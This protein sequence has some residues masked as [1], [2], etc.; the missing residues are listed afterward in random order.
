M[1]LVLPERAELALLEHAQEAGLQLRRHLG[2]FIEEQGAAR[3]FLDHA[4]EIV[5]RAGKGALHVAEKLG[6]DHVLREGGAVQFHERAVV[7]LAAAVEH[8]RDDFLADAALAG[9]EDIGIAGRNAGDEIVDLAHAAAGEDRGELL[10]HLLE[11]AGELGG[12]R[13]EVSRGR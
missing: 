8:V 2:D 3:G 12:L 5:H 1:V 9:D 11:L 13:H 4:G 10:L 7:A 6:L